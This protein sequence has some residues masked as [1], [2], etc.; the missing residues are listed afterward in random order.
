MLI[1]LC[2]YPNSGKSTVQTILTEEYGV[3]PI[4]DGRALRD[5]A[6]ITLGLTEDDVTTQEGKTKTVTVLG[7]EMSVRDYLGRIGSALE[8][9]F[10]DWIVPE[11]HARACDPNK[12]YSFGS[13]RRDQ[14]HFYRA[15]GGLVVEIRR[16]GAKPL[17]PADLYD[18]APIRYTIFNNGSLEELHEEVRVFL[19]DH[20]G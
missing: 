20:L 11:I 1:A 14:G 2:G 19:G 15:Q 16:D 5:I 17:V 12:H 9:E 13:V 4:D 8:T 6:K 10:G 18:P 3:I 7:R